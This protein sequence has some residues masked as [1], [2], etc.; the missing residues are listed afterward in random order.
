M[1]IRSLGVLSVGLLAVIL[2]ITAADIHAHA[3]TAEGGMQGWQA[4]LWHAFMHLCTYGLGAV[5]MLGLQ[6]HFDNLP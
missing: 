6:S 5:A 1:F 2:G 3:L 4:V